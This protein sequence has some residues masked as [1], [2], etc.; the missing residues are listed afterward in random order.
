MFGQIFTVLFYIFVV[1][2]ATKTPLSFIS[3]PERVR[4]LV[5]KLAAEAAVLE[6]MSRRS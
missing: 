1:L 2:L 4:E 3:H 5:E 6:L